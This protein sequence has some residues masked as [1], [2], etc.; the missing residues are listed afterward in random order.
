[1]H[2]LSF[3]WLQAKQIV[4]IASGA[5]TQLSDTEPVFIIT[6]WI[7]DPIAERDPTWRARF[8]N[9]MP[10]QVWTW[11]DGETID[12]MLVRCRKEHQ[13]YYGPNGKLSGHQ[14]VGEDVFMHAT[15]VVSRFVLAGFAWMNQKVLTLADGGLPRQRRK[16][17]QRH[18]GHNEQTVKIIQLRRVQQ[19][20]TLNDNPSEPRDEAYYS[21]R[22]EVDGH[23]RNQACGPGFSDRKLRWIDAFLKGPEDAPFRAPKHKVYV[24]NR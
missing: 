2:A 15:D 10:S 13:Q 4:D 19:I 5:I 12:E 8:G 7:P 6:C 17:Y 20:P 11:R 3:G 24:V 23:W 22:F 16:D 18:V 1:V 14:I 21:C 9:L